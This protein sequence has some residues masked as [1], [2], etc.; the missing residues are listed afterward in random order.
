MTEVPTANISHIFS[1]KY[2]DCCTA[3]G[4]EA[5]FYPII[6]LANPMRKTPMTAKAYLVLEST[7]APSKRNRTQFTLVDIAA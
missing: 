3:I 4:G 6:S 5:L 1:A 2:L 7:P